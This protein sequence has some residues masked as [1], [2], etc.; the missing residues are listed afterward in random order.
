MEDNVTII[1]FHFHINTFYLAFKF[2][3]QKIKQYFAFNWENPK[4][5]T[6]FFLLL[7]KYWIKYKNEEALNPWFLMP[8]VFLPSKLHVHQIAHFAIK[9]Q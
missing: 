1:I 4:K 7:Q 3:H 5:Q 8:V 2:L 6:R 9:T